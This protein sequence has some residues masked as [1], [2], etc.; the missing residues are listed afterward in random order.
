MLTSLKIE[1]FKGIATRQRIDFAPLKLLFGANS[2]GKSTILQ[3]L[4][5]LQ[6]LIV[7]L[8]PSSMHH[9]SYVEPPPPQK[10]DAPR[11]VLS[12]PIR[13]GVTG[14]QLRIQLMRDLEERGMERPSVRST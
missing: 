10:Q 11:L 12:G 3:A 4:L 14:L 9:R 6:E 2:A 8:N 13:D 1:N 7:A 5:Y